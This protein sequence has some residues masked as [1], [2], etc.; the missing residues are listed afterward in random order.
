MIKTIEEIKK[1]QILYGKQKIN[2]FRQS[3]IDIQYNKDLPKYLQLERVTVLMSEDH[4][5]YLD[6]LAKK[7][8]KNR[9]IKGE[10]ITAN[11]I[12]RCLIEFLKR[13]DENIDFH[14]IES[15]NQLLYRLMSAFK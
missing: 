5:N 11:C 7:L 14:D 13:S 12:L 1:D 9:R 4:K 15:E 8:M 2:E 6:F 10:R 3:S